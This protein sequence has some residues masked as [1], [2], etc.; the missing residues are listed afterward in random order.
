MGLRRKGCIGHF[1]WN[2]NLD[3][4][5]HWGKKKQ[6]F[7]TKTTLKINAGLIDPIITYLFYSLSGNNFQLC[8]HSL[9]FGKQLVCKRLKL[10]MSCFY[11]TMSYSAVVI[12][13]TCTTV[14]INIW[15][16]QTA[17]SSHHYLVKICTVSV[18]HTNSV[19]TT[20]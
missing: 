8:I 16:F 7:K 18:F 13:D 17:V 15:Q 5:D 11:R 20:L 6:G 19:S 14:V 9:W 2:R 3:F 4:G 10:K 1:N 12:S